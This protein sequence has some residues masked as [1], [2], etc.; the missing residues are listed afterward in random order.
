MLY[1]RTSITFT[2]VYNR[3]AVYDNNGNKFLWICTVIFDTLN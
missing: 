2:S 3:S 1:F